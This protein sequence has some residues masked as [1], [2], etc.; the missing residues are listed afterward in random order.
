MTILSSLILTTMTAQKV[1]KLQKRNGVFFV[2]CIVNGLKLSFVFDTGASDVSLSS[3][4][5]MFMFKN[6][7]LDSTDIV[8]KQKFLDASGYVGEAVVVNIRNIDFYGYRLTDVKASIVE[9]S[10]APLLLGQTALR[11]LGN[12][13]IDFSR[14]ELRISRRTDFIQSS[15]Y[16]R[17]DSA[18]YYHS[19]P[20]AALAYAAFIDTCFLTEMRA[21][22]SGWYLNE[23]KLSANERLA[24]C[25]KALNIYKRF[26]SL[27]AYPD[28]YSSLLL[29][30]GKVHSELNNFQAAIDYLNQGLSLKLSDENRDDLLMERGMVKHDQKQYDEA[31]SD[32]SRVKTLDRDRLN[33]VI[34][35]LILEGDDYNLIKYYTLLINSGIYPNKPYH[36]NGRARCK[37]TLKDYV[38]ALSDLDQAIGILATRK[39][40]AA[41]YEIYLRRAQ[42]RY[43]KALYSSAFEDINQALKMKPN[44]G[45][46]YL[47]RGLIQVQLGRKNS[48]CLDLSKAGEL[49][50][51]EAYEYIQ[52]VCQ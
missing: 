36:L 16:E 6:G 40:Q 4:E 41:D 52:S 30:L 27:A 45:G 21:D 31:L 44:D 38:G 42:I 51:K 32:W 9:N 28:A 12:I 25:E 24:M 43:N 8:G 48:G 10:N 14:G 47:M 22:S 34:I 26:D 50:I 5:A 3:T 18:T 13:E 23:Y 11:Q 37:A 17:S 19:F 39:E 1:V 46:C 7:F 29:A 20:E 49:G 15:T 35:Q 2:P 33:W